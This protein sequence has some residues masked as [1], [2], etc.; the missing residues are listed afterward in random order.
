MKKQRTQ[1]GSLVLNMLHTEPAKWC[2]PVADSTDL[3]WSLSLLSKCL[4]SLL[5]S[6]YHG[7]YIEKN[8]LLYLTIRFDVSTENMFSIKWRPR[9]DPPPKSSIL[10]IMLYEIRVDNVYWNGIFIFKIN[11]NILTTR[12]S[13]SP[14]ILPS[15]VQCC[16]YWQGILR[17][18]GMF[19]RNSDLHRLIG[20]G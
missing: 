3:L 17:G 20:G 12:I 4:R 2:D 19:W 9:Q 6:E 1:S 13:Y 15:L 18:E 10:G 8:F 11:F 16:E 5:H 7:E 14:P